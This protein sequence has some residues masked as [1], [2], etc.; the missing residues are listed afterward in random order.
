MYQIQTFDLLPTKSHQTHYPKIDNSDSGSNHLNY[1][2]SKQMKRFENI[3]QIQQPVNFSYKGSS[4]WLRVAEK[5]NTSPG[6][7]EAK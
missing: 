5:E 3:R 6:S 7:E 4:S 2:A 1:S